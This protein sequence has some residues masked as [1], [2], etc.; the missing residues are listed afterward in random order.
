MVDDHRHCLGCGR[1][2]SRNEQFCS[3]ECEQTFF[4]SAQKERRRNLTFLVILGMFLSLIF[5]VQLFY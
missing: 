2:I 5:I 4:A 3:P 1:A